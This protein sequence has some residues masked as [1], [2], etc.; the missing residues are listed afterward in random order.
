MSDASQKRV[1]AGRD[2]SSIGNWGNPGANL[3]FGLRVLAKRTRHEGGLMSQLAPTTRALVRAQ[4]G[5]VRVDDT[6]REQVRSAVLSFLDAAVTATGRETF[7]NTREE[8]LAAEKAIHQ[9]AF[10]LDRGLYG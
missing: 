6:A 10:A 9:A 8:Q 7:Y 3:S 5:A 4:D 1:A 2:R